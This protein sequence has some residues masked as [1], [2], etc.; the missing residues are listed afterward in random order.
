MVRCDIF[1]LIQTFDISFLIDTIDIASRI[2][3]LTLNCVN[4][5][6]VL[7]KLCYDHSVRQINF[8]K[9]TKHSRERGGGRKRLKNEKK[10][11]FFNEEMKKN[12]G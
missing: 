12:K 3:W 4:L 6:H 7:L 5:L 10:T 9:N 8:E 2:C 11:I 1:F